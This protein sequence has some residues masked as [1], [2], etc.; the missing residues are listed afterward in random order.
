[1]YFLSSKGEDDL[2]FATLMALSSFVYIFIT[3]I[4]SSVRDKQYLSRLGQEY[5]YYHGAYDIFFVLVGI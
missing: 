5:Q 3:P 1:M 4:S 2:R